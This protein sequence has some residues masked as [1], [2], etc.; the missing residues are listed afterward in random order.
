MAGRK[1]TCFKHLRNRTL[2]KTKKKTVCSNLICCHK[3]MNKKGLVEKNSVDLISLLRSRNI[4]QRRIRFTATSPCEQDLISDPTLGSSLVILL[5]SL[6]SPRLVKRSLRHSEGRFGATNTQWQSIKFLGTL[7][8][9]SHRFSFV[10]KARMLSKRYS[11]LSACLPPSTK[12]TP[13][14]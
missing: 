12:T 4:S 8:K 5:A 14:V 1:P 7:P 11:G 9:E 3:S 6:W 13:S 2:K 10:S